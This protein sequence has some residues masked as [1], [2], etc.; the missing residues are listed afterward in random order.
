MPVSPV[1]ETPCMHALVSVIV[2]VYNVTPYLPQCVHS[3]L[4][5]T[6]APVE[7]VLVDDGSTDGSGEIC[8][9]LAKE[10]ARVRVLHRDNGGQ[11]A[12]KNT[13][14]EAAK[15]A[16]LSFVDGDDYVLPEMYETMIRAM[17][18]SGASICECAFMYVYPDAAVHTGG[19]TGDVTVFP[20]AE[21]IRRMALSDPLM[22]E[23]A[24]KVY[25]RETIGD[26]R[27]P[28][29]QLYEEVGFLRRVAGR[30]GSVAYVDRPFYQY[31]QQRAGN[32]NASF[33][34]A[35]LPVLEEC[36]AFVRMLREEG[37]SDAADAM[38]AFA[39]DH[40]MRMFCNAKR[41]GAGRDIRKRLRRA[42]RTRYQQEKENPYVRK[43]RGLLFCIS[44]DAYDWL[45][46]RL[47]SR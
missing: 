8:D 36:T 11:S 37:L 31:R 2:P 43:L 21:A 17:E 12:A 18:E 23:S 38:A 1:S 47:H 30:I 39:L 33:P 3:L 15:G 14:I 29:K 4:T 6:Y 22:I 41:C 10:D 44:P 35:K 42:Y 25:R 45:S 24:R 7:V 32:T 16:Y 40:N 34:A 46:R 19:D 28:E 9:T 20:R 5:Q 26:A 13:G 27:F